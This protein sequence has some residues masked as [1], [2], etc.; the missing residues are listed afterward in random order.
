[1]NDHKSEKA[2]TEL[3]PESEGESSSERARS[4]RR[5]N[6]SIAAETSVNMDELREL[7]QL[8]RENDFTEF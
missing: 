6:R 2:G 4:R 8:I 3:P 5:R 1:M 7:I